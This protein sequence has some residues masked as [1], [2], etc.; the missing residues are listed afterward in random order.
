MQTSLLSTHDSYKNAYGD[1]HTRVRLGHPLPSPLASFSHIRNATY[2]RAAAEKTSFGTPKLDILMFPY[3]HAFGPLID[4]NMLMKQLQMQA[5]AH[6]Q[7]WCVGRCAHGYLVGHLGGYA[8][9]SSALRA[10]RA[11]AAPRVACGRTP[12]NS[13]AAQGS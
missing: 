2:A 11:D 5:L 4:K 12:P 1:C 7:T 10:V 9:H 3:H 6:A 13:A 8:S